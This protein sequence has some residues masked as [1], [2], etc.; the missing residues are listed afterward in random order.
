MRNT[1]EIRVTAEGRDKGKVY[2]IREMSSYDGERWGIRMMEALMKGGV[3]IP[4][5]FADA[6]GG[7]LALY[8]LGMRAICAA[9]SDLTLPLFDEMFE[10][11]LTVVPD[12]KNP[13]ITRGAPPVH[14]GESVGPLIDDD[15]EE[16]KTRAML[17]GEIFELH[18]GFSA[19]AALS[20]LWKK[21]MENL[22]AAKD[23][24]T[25]QSDTP[26]SDRSADV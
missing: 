5:G 1:K 17:R 11:C 8:A 18:T 4:N 24:S 7:L 26:I 15:I 12:P 25:S 22:A 21:G 3:D 14:G 2:V 9:P 6:S 20:Q 19:A 13:L 16:I 23:E 10:K